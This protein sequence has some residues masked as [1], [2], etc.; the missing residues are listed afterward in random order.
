MRILLLLS[1]LFLS[2]CDFIDQLGNM[3][4]LEIRAVNPSEEQVEAADME[5]VSV[6]FSQE[7]NRKSAEGAF[8]LAEEE[9]SLE[10]TFRWEERRMFFTPYH[11][12][13]ENREY[14][15]TVKKGAEDRYG[16]SLP[17][18][19]FY[20]FRTGSDETPPEILSISPEDY[21]LITARRQPVVF[22]FSEP[23]DRQSFRDAFS[24]SPSLEGKQ[25]WDAD[26]RR[27]TFTPLADYE[28]GEE[29]TFKVGT[30]LT[31]PAENPLA[32][33]FSVLY[34]TAAVPD[35]ALTSLILE[36]SGAPLIPGSGGINEGAEKDDR[37]SGSFDRP[38]DG[39]ERK[40][41]LEILP[42][43]PFETVWN[44][45]FDTF[46]VR[47]TE[48]LVWDGWY[49]LKIF[50]SLYVIHVSGGESRPPEVTGL[51]F[52]PD[53]TAPVPVLTPLSLN[54]SLG[55]AD[56]ASAFLD[57]Y[58]TTAAGAVID[59]FSFMDALSLDSSVLGFENRFLEV[60]DGSQ[61][62][63]PAPAPAADETV[64][65]LHLTVTDY[66]LPGTVSVSLADTLTDSLDNSLAE[67]WVLTVSQP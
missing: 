49:D 53:G 43:A 7:M 31:D 46:E 48:P 38:L 24:V 8:S 47:F 14:L 3:E 54:S 20:R 29:Y 33:D 61:T 1:F 23:V 11:G 15:I 56:S 26:S 58:I 30:D 36:S 17:E 40:T 16:N 41:F 27:V 18:D 44:S 19:R 42:E 22:S 2:G 32:S 63:P 9:Q 51:T 21:T 67:K 35:P 57:F 6:A 13:H 45:A 55:A 39:E 65:R 4:P 64:L 28:A 50:D 12:F 59:R 66:G 62:P 5:A 52:C 25:E 34:R 60:L 10:G 37:V